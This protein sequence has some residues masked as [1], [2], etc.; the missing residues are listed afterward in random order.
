MMTDKAL[1][2]LSFRFETLY[3]STGR[4]SASPEQLLRALLL[5]VLYSVRSERL[6]IKAAAVHVTLEREVRVRIGCPRE[7]PSGDFIT[8]YQIV[9]AGDEKVRSAAGLDSVQSL[10][11]VFTMIGTDVGHGLKDCRFQWANSDDS[12]FPLP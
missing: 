1:L 6:L 5:Q 11:L 3:A 7:T 9:G 4:P 8:P 10:Q 12:G 2:T